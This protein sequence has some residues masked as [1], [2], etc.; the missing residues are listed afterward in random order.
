MYIYTMF[1][2]LD[3]LIVYNVCAART[4]MKH[5]YLQDI[6]VGSVPEAS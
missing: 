3:L 5:S 2:V 1:S 4:T 6:G